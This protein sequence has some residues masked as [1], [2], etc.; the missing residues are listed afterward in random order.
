M[1]AIIA[2][3]TRARRERLRR[4]A[5]VANDTG[6]LRCHYKL[7]EFQTR[8]DPKT[9]NKY[10]IR[11]DIHITFSV[12]SKK[13]SLNYTQFTTFRREELRIRKEEEKILE[14]ILQQIKSLQKNNIPFTW[15]RCILETCLLG[16]PIFK[17]TL[18]S[19]EGTTLSSLFCVTLLV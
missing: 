1:A 6:E 11:Y 7:P 19:Y 14:E 18:V 3:L 10:C 4:M 12:N 5:M 2:Q 17:C 13:V 16:I 15:T 8:F 9:H